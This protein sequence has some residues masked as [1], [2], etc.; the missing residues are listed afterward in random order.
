MEFSWQ[1]SVPQAM[2]LNY[3]NLVENNINKYCVA[4]TL[5]PDVERYVNCNFMVFL[6][7]SIHLLSIKWYEFI[8]Q[9]LVYSLVTINLQSVL[10]L[11]HCL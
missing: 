1:T 11:A 9:D 6:I 5:C 3:S 10:L 7:V 8:S 2:H 4:Y